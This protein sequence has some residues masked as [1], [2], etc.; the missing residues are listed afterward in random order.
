MPKLV[1]KTLA[2]QRMLMDAEDFE[3]QPRALE[4]LILGDGGYML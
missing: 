2:D 4:E 1:R 3:R